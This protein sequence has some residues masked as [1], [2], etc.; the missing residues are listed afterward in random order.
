[1]QFELTGRSTQTWQT[2][3]HVCTAQSREMLLAKPPL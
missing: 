2:D 1:M 3:G